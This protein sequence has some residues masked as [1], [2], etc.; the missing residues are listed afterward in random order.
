MITKE[1]SEAAT[2]VNKILS[3]LPEEYVEK[4]PIKLRE[5]FK[6]IESKDYI[7]NIDPYKSIDKQELQPKTKTLL[8]VI[9]RDYWCN[10]EERKEIDKVLIENDKRYEEELRKKYNPDNIFKKK[11]EEIKEVEETTLIVYNNGNW[12]QRALS[13]ISNILKKYLKNKIVRK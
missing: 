4:I 7:P 5:F 3:Y 13:F 11:D 10:E 6:N 12:Y 1:F 8:T 2:E 9:Y